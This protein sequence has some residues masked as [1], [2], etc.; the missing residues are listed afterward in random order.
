LAV[1]SAL[2]GIGLWIWMAM[3]NKAGKSWARIMASVLFGLNT[4]FLFT[5]FTRPSPLGSRLVM[6]L[7]WLIGLGTVLFLWRNESSQYF[8]AG[9]N[10]AR[11]GGRGQPPP[12]GPHPGG[13]GRP[14]GQ[15]R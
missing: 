12:G 7:I 6:I 4:L 2:L 14:G 15:R 3:A 10:P 5:G 1:F 8:E 11:P 13:T 9:R